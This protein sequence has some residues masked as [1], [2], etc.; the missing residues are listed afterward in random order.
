MDLGDILENEEEDG[1]D[2][3]DDYFGEDYDDEWS[4]E[5]DDD[6]NGGSSTPQQP[7]QPQQPILPLAGSAPQGTPDAPFFFTLVDPDVLAENKE[8]I[9]DFDRGMQ[10]AL[11]YL[12]K[13]ANR[14]ALDKETL[15]V[16]NAYKSGVDAH[17]YVSLARYFWPDPSSPNGLP[18]IR[19]DGQVNP[20]IHNAPDYKSFR[21]MVSNRNVLKIF[22]P[23]SCKCVFETPLTPPLF[24]FFPPCFVLSPPSLIKR[25][26]KS[27]IS[28]WLTTFL[29]MKP[30]Q[31]R[32]YSVF[33][34]G[35]LIPRQE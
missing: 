33:T 2:D 11:W 27:S 22:K 32:Q 5:H 23:D 29:T 13:S 19:V 1:D 30:M 17:N 21:Q 10:H 28:L 24:F 34:N 26:N 14:F 35:L 16:V 25:R 18:Y 6:H 8:H 12:K 31:T 7:Q 9:H 20:E 3:D 4:D 15:S